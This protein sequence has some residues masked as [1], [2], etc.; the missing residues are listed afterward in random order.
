MRQTY[1]YDTGPK[2]IEFSIQTLQNKQDGA[3]F[4]RSLGLSAT[5]VQYV[6]KN[7]DKL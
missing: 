6:Q 4:G 7:L 1:V 5:Q 3:A 2:K